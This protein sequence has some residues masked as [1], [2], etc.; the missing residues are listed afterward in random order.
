[1][2]GMRF[3]ATVQL[4]GK[5]ATGIHVPDDVVLGLGAGKRAAVRVTIGPHTYRTTVAPYNGV[6]MLPLSAENRVAAGVSA[7][8]EVDVD[9]ELDDQPRV[10]VVPTDLAEALD[11]DPAVRGAF[12]ALSYTNRNAYVVSVEGAKTDETRRRRIARC[13]AEVS[14]LT[15]PGG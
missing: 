3:R 11:A 8:E 1:M 9:L 6:F 7:G 10:V 2:R 15:P 5:T 12:D 14:A 4:A 13:V